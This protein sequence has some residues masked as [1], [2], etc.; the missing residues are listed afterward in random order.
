VRDGLAT[1][2]LLLSAFSE[3]AIVYKALEQGAAGFLPKE[4]TPE[5]IAD[6]VVACAGGRNVVPPELASALVSQ[7][8]LRA[9]IEAPALSQRERE[10][11]GLI[12]AGK[13]VR[14]IA[15][16]LFL[17]VSTVKTHVQHLYEKLGVSDRAAAV[18]EAMRH[19]LIE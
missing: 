2:V 14:E 6:A 5:E 7:I 16:E 12:A 13:T 9:V 3:S 4:A 10:I 19:G 18:A 8:R 1:R 17:S 11:L 15:R